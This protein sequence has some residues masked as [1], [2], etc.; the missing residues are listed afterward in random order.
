MEKDT[1]SGLNR[2]R[3][4]QQQVIV[5]NLYIQD[6]F[7]KGYTTQLSYHFNKDD[8][9]IHFDRN[10]FL[11]RPAPIGVVQA[12]NVRSHYIGWTGNGHMGKININH[13]A[14]QVLGHD[15]LNPISGHYVDINA[16]MAAVELSMDRDWLR[17]RTSF[18]YASG[19]KNARDNV[20][21]GFDSIDEA[22]TFAGGVFSFFNREGIRLT[23]TGVGLVPPD[24]FLPSL[25]SSKE[26]GQSNFVNPGLLLWNAGVD[27]DITPKL[28]AV[29][30]VNFMRFHRTGA[31]EQLLFESK[32]ATSI[33]TDYSVGLIYRPPLSENITITGGVAALTPGLGLRQIY[34][35]KTLVSSFGVIKFQF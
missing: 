34:T 35:S 23:G 11:T 16:Q 20:A 5:A 7:F 31:L 25:R 18:F 2:F 12:H 3:R 17:F 30:N 33:G 24:S 9:S 1:N 27:A 28:R 10:N 32:I 15:D 13:A 21:R 19:D 8:A 22:Q 6:V 29:T 26:E 14:Y 4:R